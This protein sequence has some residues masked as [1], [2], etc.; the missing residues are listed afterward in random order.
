[1]VNEQLEKLKCSEEYRQLQESE[2]DF[3][4]LTIFEDV[5]HENS[6]SR[7]IAFLCSS[8]NKHNLG[9]RFFREWM[10]Q[11]KNIKLPPSNSCYVQTYF[12]WSTQ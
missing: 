12:N 6:Y 2:N 8:N 10:K 9:Q 11:I 7:I 5:F 3:N 1:M 4:I